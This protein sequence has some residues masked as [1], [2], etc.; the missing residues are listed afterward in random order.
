MSSLPDRP[1]PISQ[2]AFAKSYGGTLICGFFAILFYGV[3]LLQTYMYYLKYTR[4]TIWMK[5]LVLF[6]T[7]LGT[8]Q[9]GLICTTIYTYLVISYTNPSILAGGLWS[10][11]I[12]VI[13]G[14]IVCV[15][16][17]TFFAKMIYHLTSGVK[18]YLLVTGFAVF[19]ISEFAFGICWVVMEFKSAT[20]AQLV[21]WV[22]KL[23]VPLR[24]L[25]MV[26]DGTTTL[27][28][29][30]ILFDANVQFKPSVK[31]IRTI[32]IYAINRFI[33]TTIV[34][35]VQT[36]LM[37][38]DPH[39]ISALSIEFIAVHL[40]I[41]SFLAALNA[42]NRIRGANHR[43]SSS[44]ISSSDL[45]NHNHNNLHPRSPTNVNI[46]LPGI[47]TGPI[48]PASPVQSNFSPQT[49]TTPH[50]LLDGIP[51]SGIAKTS[52]MRRGLKIHVDTESFVMRD[53]E[54]P[55]DDGD[56]DDEVIEDRDRKG[57]SSLESHV[58]P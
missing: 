1:T 47:N 4:D 13:L 29:C 12:G 22:S 5:L 35:C 26:S 57:S 6:I 53:L 10:V 11:Y 54:S 25:R 14:Y 21:P 55:G 34:G 2:S 17:Q 33:L 41:N 51:S 45:H 38:V 31:L 40:Y 46:S 49:P 28:L 8:V 37:L 27:S 39:S 43:V 9:I 19:I 24:I 15:I 3:S 23:L 20:L 52:T 36:I 18:R 50:G 44:Y 42:R 32:I 48:S 56:G 16:I 58:L 30:L 7:I